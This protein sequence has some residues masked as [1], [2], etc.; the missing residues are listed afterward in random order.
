MR[1]LLIPPIFHYKDAFPTL[2]SA[3]DF[4]SGFAYVASALEKAGHTVYGLNL[5]NKLGFKTGYDLASD[6]IPKAIDKVKPDLIGLG[7]LCTDYHFIKDAIEI[8][9]KSSKVPIVLGGGIVNNDAE[10]IFNLLKPDYA[11]IGEGEETIVRL[12]NSL[13]ELTKATQ[14]NGS[15]SITCTV[16]TMDGSKGFMGNALQ[17]LVGDL[18]GIPN[19][20]FW[21]DNKAVSTEYIFSSGDI[22][23]IPF[24]DYEPFGVREMIDDYSMATRLLYR[25]S[26]QYPRPYNI[27]T[28]RGCPFRCSFCVDESHKR[29]PYRARSMDNIFA[30]I[31]ES[32]EQYKYNILIILDE[33]FVANKKRM[34]EFCE[35]LIQEKKTNEWDFD[36]MF[37][38]HANAHL[39]LESLKLAKEAGCYFFSYGLE[40]CSQRILDSMKKKTKVAQAV[41]A[42]RLAE[43]ANVGFGGNIIFGDPAETEETISESLSVW[44]EH[45]RSAMVFLSFVQAYPGSKLF[46]CCTEK[47]I[48]KDKKYYY[49]HI[50][51]GLFNM[52]SIPDDILN[53]WMSLINTIERSW[54]QVKTA[55]GTCEE[56]KE[57]LEVKYLTLTG[58]KMYKLKA[59]CPYCGEEVVYRQA[60][61]DKDKDRGIGV[62]CVKCNKRIKVIIK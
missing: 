50:D 34:R 20:L 24:P 53:K 32:Y 44:Y 4:P 13:Q 21:K 2:L 55:Y 8:I 47:G 25:Y 30:E 42:V 3:S 57:A 23:E 1:I 45:F 15:G 16:S 38:T 62:G 17:F 59:K 52:T 22:N 12:V 56:D 11:I 49:E 31:K 61:A 48:I 43:E 29:S 51:E 14:D 54:L 40:S 46:D 33:L 36:W 28:S 37:Q 6:K 9:R 58:T 10:F 19:M 39:D 18:S 60:F 26:R 35:R 41:E 5:N 27:I 7:G